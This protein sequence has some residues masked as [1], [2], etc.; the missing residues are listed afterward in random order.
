MNRY[1]RVNILWDKAIKALCDDIQLFSCALPNRIVLSLVNESHSMGWPWER[2]SERNPTHAQTHWVFQLSV[3]RCNMGWK[4]QQIL[5]IFVP[6]SSVFTRQKRDGMCSVVL[7]SDS[8]VVRP[9][10]NVPAVS[11]R[12]VTPQFN[13]PDSTSSQNYCQRSQ[14][15]ELA[16]RQGFW[17]WEMCLDCKLS[18]IAD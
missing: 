4:K 11:N 12:P 17:H 15:P 18:R 10:Q 2:V 5:E 6:A 3:S 9:G 13:R 1:L 7:C 16:Y 8:T 14:N